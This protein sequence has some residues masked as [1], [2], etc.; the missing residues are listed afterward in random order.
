MRAEH[1]LGQR[2]WH[3]LRDA[4]AGLLETQGCQTGTAGTELPGNKPGTGKCGQ[5]CPGVPLVPAEEEECPEMR[6]QPAFGRVPHHIPAHPCRE[7]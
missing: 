5:Q 7:G 1:E 3:P 2:H 6:A 4:R